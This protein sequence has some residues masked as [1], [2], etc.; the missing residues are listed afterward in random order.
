MIK[1]VFKTEILW[2]LNVI[3][4]INLL[5]LQAQTLYLKQCFQIQK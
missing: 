3:T 2:N 4:K 5:D 1:S